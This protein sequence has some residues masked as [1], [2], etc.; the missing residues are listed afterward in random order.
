VF[1]FIRRIECCESK[2][3]IRLSSYCNFT[4]T[5]LTVLLSFFYNWK[6]ISLSQVNVMA[7]TWVAQ[8]LSPEFRII[9]HCKL[10]LYVLL[11]FLSA[12]T[13]NEKQRKINDESIFFSFINLFFIWLSFSSWCRKHRL[14]IM[15]K[16]VNE[17]PIKSCVNFFF[18]GTDILF[19]FKFSNFDKFHI[20]KMF[21][22]QLSCLCDEWWMT[23]KV[24][25][26]TP[27]NAWRQSNV[28]YLFKIFF[29]SM[30]TRF[31][32]KI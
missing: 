29:Y 5:F 7:G 6:H 11:T 2:T 17:R 18:F 3:G 32:T 26:Y 14:I 12:K 4:G 8:M 16:I 20:L 31:R 21:I 24:F 28:R 23:K 9:L 19:G 22:V 27:S 15:K 1:S 10:L 30:Q 13:V 25:S